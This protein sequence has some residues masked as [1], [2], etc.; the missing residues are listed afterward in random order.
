MRV[1]MGKPY[2]ALYRGTVTQLNVLDRERV[3]DKSVIAT[4]MPTD[5]QG[6]SLTGGRS[7][8]IYAPFD[9]VVR[10]YIEEGSQFDHGETLFHV[11]YASADHDHTDE[12]PDYLK[13][14]E[15]ILQHPDMLSTSFGIGSTCLPLR[16]MLSADNADLVND[17]LDALAA[18]LQGPNG[19][20]RR[21]AA[22]AFG[23]LGLD[24]P[25]ILDLLQHR[26]ADD[27]A[28]DV[29]F[30]IGVS[31]ATLRSRPRGTGAKET[32]RRRSLEK[33]RAQHG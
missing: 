33:L 12:L 23:Q 21:I 4:I 9:G 26:K 7:G 22:L 27:P 17:A 30:A 32:D 3:R 14:A 31:L 5:D 20:Y 19:N 18:L 1:G 25:P 15:V 11:E 8:P 6:R 10:L 2:R 29:L 16:E 13:Q 28:P 24:L